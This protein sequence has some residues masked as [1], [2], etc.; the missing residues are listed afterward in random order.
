MG[1]DENIT[2][3]RS[4]TANPE[5]KDHYLCFIPKG[6]SSYG[7]KTSQSASIIYYYRFKQ[8]TINEDTYNFYEEANSQL[9]ASGKLFD[10]I[11]TQLYGN[12]ECTSDPSRIVL[13]LFE[14]SSVTQAAFVI[15][16]SPR[17]VT[18]L[19]VPAKGYYEYKV[20]TSIGEEIVD[21]DYDVIPYP[22]W[23]YHND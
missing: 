18:Y 14:V 4:K 19:D 20:S 9:A 11:T 5:I 21:P 13:G 12:M 17:Q 8:Y 15:T 2:E 6:T 3:E 10:P 7:F 22:S 23:W 16:K 1:D